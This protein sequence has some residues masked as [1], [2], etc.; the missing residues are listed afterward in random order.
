MI[1]SQTSRGSFSAVSTPIFASK[2]SLESSRRDLH[3]ALLCT[4]LQSQNFS[5]KSSTC[6]RD[7]IIE[8]N[9]RFVFNFFVEFCIFS[10]NCWWIFIRISRQIPENSDV[11]RFFNQICENTLE[12]YR[13]FRKFWKYYSILFNF[14]QSCPY[15]WVRGRASQGS[16]KRSRA[17]RRGCPPPEACACHC[18][19][20]ATT[21][22][23]ER[24]PLGF[25]FSFAWR[26]VSTR[27]VLQKLSM[28]F[29][30]VK[31]AR[32]HFRPSF[33]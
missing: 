5:Q 32:L 24:D 17:V 15:L 30:L 12:N 8:K 19:C 10:A 14:I 2:Y 20:Q 23:A 7:W 11:C 28:Q 9:F 25:F 22:A 18:D 6:F 1:F 13:N 26:L 16:A 33:R 4:I 21:S 29:S 27:G 31:N 3:N